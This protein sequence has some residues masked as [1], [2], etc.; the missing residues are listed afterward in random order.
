LFDHTG[1]AARR[2]HLLVGPAQ[3]GWQRWQGSVAALYYQRVTLPLQW[4]VAAGRPPQFQPQL[5]W[6]QPLVWRYLV[7]TG[8]QQS[9]RRER[10]A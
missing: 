2:W 6:W 8:W 1:S 3:R 5:P 10:P 9:R 4:W 7:I